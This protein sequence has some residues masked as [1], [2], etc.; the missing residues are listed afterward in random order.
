MRLKRVKGLGGMLMTDVASISNNLMQSDPNITA[1]ALVGMNGGIIYQTQNW[2]IQ[3]QDIISAF[4]SK[5]PSVVVQGIKYSTINAT[6]DRMIATNIQ[7]MGHLVVAAVG[8]KALFICYLTSQ[9]S[10]QSA[11]IAADRAAREI[12]KII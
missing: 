2:T 3:G 12:N 11:Y 5:S 10:P 1:T 6:Q 4:T 7:G 9:G 8:Q